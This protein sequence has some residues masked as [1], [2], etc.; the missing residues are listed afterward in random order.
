MT[1]HDD[2]KARCI[3]CGE[4][5]LG[6]NCMVQ[7]NTNKRAWSEEELKQVLRN[8]HFVTKTPRDER[9]YHFIAVIDWL[10]QSTEQ[11][12]PKLSHK[13]DPVEQSVNTKQDCDACNGDGV[14]HSCPIPTESSPAEVP[15]KECQHEYKL[16]GIAGGQ[17][18]V[19]FCNDCGKYVSDQST[20]TTLPEIA[21]LD[22]KGYSAADTNDLA[23]M[24]G[25]LLHTTNEL[26]RIVNKLSGGSKS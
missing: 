26:I 18:G 6:P 22:L 25:Q 14:W 8:Y 1:P 23:F 24:I 21:D 11:E 17:E 7:S 20:Q 3:D 9:Y 12:T 16:Y 15:E 13:E 2:T 4:T 5:N 10:S 19:W